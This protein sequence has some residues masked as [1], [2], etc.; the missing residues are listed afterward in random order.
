M[1]K[2]VLFMLDSEGLIIVNIIKGTINAGEIFFS[3]FAS[4]SRMEISRG[5]STTHYLLKKV[6]LV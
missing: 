1:H 4:I 5:F 3:S 2:I 6:L